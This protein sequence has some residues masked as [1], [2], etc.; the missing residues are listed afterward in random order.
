MKVYKVTLQIID[1]DQLGEED[2]KMQIE[3]VR[4]PN[5]CLSPKVRHIEVRDI[6]KWH[7]NNPLNNRATAAKEFERLF[8]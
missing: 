3:N 8:G 1:F 6:G 4:Y 2:I 5:D 7:D